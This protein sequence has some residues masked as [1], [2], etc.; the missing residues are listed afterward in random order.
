MSY[1]KKTV[2][3][4]SWVSGFRVSSRVI[5]FFRII[6][7]ARILS[8]SQFGLFGIATLVLAFLEILTETGIN[9]FLVQQDDEIDHYI[10]NAWLISILRGTVIFFAILLLSPLIAMFFNSPH[11]VSLLQLISLVPLIRGFINPSIVKYQKNFHFQKEFYYR[12]VIFLF[13]SFVAVTLA[14]LTK[15]ASSFVWG[16]VAGAI[17]EVFL[18]FIFLHPRPHFTTNFTHVKRIIHSGKWVTLFGVFNFIAQKGDNIM[19]G[20]IM[21]TTSL[22]IYEMGYN[23]STLPISEVSDVVNKVVFPIYVKI[24]NDYQRL[25]IAF[26]KIMLIVSSVVILFSTTIFLLPKEVIILFLGEKWLD[27]FPI[28]KILAIYGLLRGILGTTA[29]LFLSLKKQR[30]VA[31][32]TFVRVITLMVLVYPFTMQWGLHGTSMSALL[33]VVAEVPIALYYIDKIFLKTNRH[34]KK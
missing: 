14:V 12:L 21:G 24:R 8:P 28:L 22:G 10:D 31:I 13:D 2:I 30:Y 15:D 4:V 34:E 3:G 32:M 19:V 16:L 5:T 27:V 17:L 29:S 9:V 26:F 18:S 20:R 7:L 6:V 1:L 11:V 25:R 23:L 33:S